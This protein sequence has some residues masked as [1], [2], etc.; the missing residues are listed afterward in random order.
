[1]EAQI[2]ARAKAP[3]FTTGSSAYSTVEAYVP[4]YAVL[5]EGDPVDTFTAGGVYPG[6]NGYCNVHICTMSACL[7]GDREVV[8]KAIAGGP[9]FLFSSLAAPVFHFTRPGGLAAWWPGHS[10]TAAWIPKDGCA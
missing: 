10:P 1:M 6:A 8:G 7:G 4:N 9:P 5:Q 2:T 3:A